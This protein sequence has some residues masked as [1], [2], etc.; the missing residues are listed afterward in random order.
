[1]KCSGVRL[2]PLM[3][4][5]SFTWTQEQ[6]ITSR[7]SLINQELHHRHRTDTKKNNFLST[8]KACRPLQNVPC[9]ET[10]CLPQLQQQQQPQGGSPFLPHSLP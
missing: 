8:L 9:M 5:T 3:S 6:A 4:T 10:G 1:M 2:L 7:S